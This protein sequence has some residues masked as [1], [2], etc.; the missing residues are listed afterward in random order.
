V[1]ALIVGSLALIAHAPALRN[2][3]IFDDHSEIE[4]NPLMRAPLSVRT[5]LLSE[6][7]GTAAQTG[8]YRPVPLLVQRVLYG[9]WRE[10]PF[11]YHVVVLF[12]HVFLSGLLAWILAARF[13]L[14]RGGLLAGALFA[15]HTVHSETVGTGYGL[16]EVLAALFSLGALAVL[17]GWR[18]DSPKARVARVLGVTRR[19]VYMRLKR[20][21]IARMKVPKTVKGVLV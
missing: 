1:I 21:D 12:G 18:E 10:R 3:L 17:L 7:M 16:K 9:A 20:Y 5:L 8:W 13:A 14:P 15:V 2:Q 11:P 19:T 4:E 6:Y